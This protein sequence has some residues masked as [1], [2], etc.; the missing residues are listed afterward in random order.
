MTHEHG[1]ELCPF[2]DY[3]TSSCSSSGVEASSNAHPDV[4]A[5]RGQGEDFRGRIGRRKS[6]NVANGVAL[7][8][9]G[10]SSTPST[11]GGARG[12]GLP[13]CQALD[14]AWSEG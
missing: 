14:A 11:I 4:Q 8:A 9:G 1:T 2:F 12:E 7:E 3:C 6:S 5:R 13:L 10:F